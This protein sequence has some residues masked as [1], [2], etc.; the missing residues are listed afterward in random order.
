MIEIAFLGTSASAP[1]V[2]RGLAAALVMHGENR[3]LVD[4]GEGT[5]RQLLKSGLGFKRLHTILLTHGHLDHILGLAGLI[6][7]FARWEAIESVGIWGGEWA[8]DRVRALMAVVFGVDEPD[9]DLTYRSVTAGVLWEAEGLRLLAFP[10][11]HRG[12]GCFGYLFEERERRPFLAERAEQLGVPKGPER[13]ALVRGESITLPDGRVIEADE[14][15]GPTR[16][17]ARLAYVGDAASTRDLLPHVRDVDALVIESTYLAVEKDLAR[18]FGHITAG[19]AAQLALD[20][21]VG[22]LL[23]THVSRRYHETEILTEAQAVFANTVVARD[24]DQFRVLA[25]GAGE[26]S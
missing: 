1:S 15:L 17:G 9:Y 4:C 5:Q 26:P 6:S 3:F 19:E 22:Q 20:A 14:V 16:P 12:P 2:R 7:T 13:A 11:R 8:L 10:V 21:N 23:L 24:F 18:R 25:R